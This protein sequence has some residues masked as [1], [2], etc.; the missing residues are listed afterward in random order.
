MRVRCRALAFLS[1]KGSCMSACVCVGL[2]M[3][4]GEALGL[5][6]A[7][8]AMVAMAGAYDGGQWRAAGL[9]I[10]VGRIG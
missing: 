5:L 7:R 8:N 4:K 3:A 6:S 1:H 10:V 2:V 9:T